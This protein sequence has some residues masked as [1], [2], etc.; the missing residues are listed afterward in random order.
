MLCDD[1]MEANTKT[2][3]DPLVL[4]GVRNFNSALRDAP[5]Y[6]LTEHVVQMVETLACKRPSAILNGLP[7]C[8]LPHPVIWV[9]MAYADFLKATNR[10][11]G[12]DNLRRIP[13]A[14][15]PHRIGYLFE[16]LDGGY[17][18]ITIGWVHH[19][20]ETPLGRMPSALQLCILDW[21]INTSSNFHGPPE[22][23]PPS[24]RYA[25]N[26]YL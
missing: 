1:F 20:I 3:P 4:E 9:E 14:D 25:Q 13:E 10:I 19:N 5:K 21:T 12:I 22:Y 16:Q 18:R 11:I 17:I 7:V 2:V 6:V 23:I 15:N 8:F 26:S 24:E